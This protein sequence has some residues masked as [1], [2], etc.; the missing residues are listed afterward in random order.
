MEKF[1]FVIKGFGPVSYRM[2][3]GW[4]CKDLSKLS[5]RSNPKYSQELNRT[6][7]QIHATVW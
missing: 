2:D 6:D 3:E 5:K 1:T 4:T 7:D